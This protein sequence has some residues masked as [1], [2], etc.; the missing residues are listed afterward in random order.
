MTDVEALRQN[1]GETYIS[2]GR[3]AP[4][5]RVTQSDSMWSCSSRF[6]HPIGNFATH[7]RLSSNE[8]ERIVSNAEAKPHFRAYVMD[9]DRPADLGKR[10]ERVGLKPRY[11]LAGM[12]A[13][14]HGEHGDTILERDSSKERI[15]VTAKF[16]SDTFFWRSDRD[17]RRSLTAL[18]AASADSQE[19]Y[20]MGDGSGTVAAAALSITGSVAGLYNLCV[21]QDRRSA[22][23]GTRAVSQMLRLA[24][25]RNLRLVL[26][27]EDSLA[28]WYSAQGFEKGAEL[29]AYSL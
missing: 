26:Q 15:S 25:E 8:L 22:G 9:G 2:L 16:V 21:R 7:F 23:I 18:L 5:A 6:A 29:V 20:S 24:A 19:F 14:A 3:N 1:V 4:G 27:C 17:T 11:K 28:S 10:L 13:G 12:V